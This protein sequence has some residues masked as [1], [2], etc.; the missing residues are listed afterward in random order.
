MTDTALPTLAPA[1][2][3]AAPVEE[4]RLLESQAELEVEENPKL[5]RREGLTPAQPA[6]INR[7]PAATDPDAGRA[8][9][10]TATR[11]QE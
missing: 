4:T 6:D 8:A 2:D 5:A 1:A 10:P 3:A 11:T 9:A 7:D